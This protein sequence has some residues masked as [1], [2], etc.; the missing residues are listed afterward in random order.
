M[1]TGFP[2][3]IFGLGKTVEQIATIA[4]RL[5]AR[6]D[7]ILVTRATPEAFAAVEKKVRDACYNPVSR[8]IVVNRQPSVTF[9]RVSPSLQ[10]APPIF[11]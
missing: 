10:E 1:R 9:A 5:A 6:S 4:E 8:T 2:E 11:R 7:K 3:V